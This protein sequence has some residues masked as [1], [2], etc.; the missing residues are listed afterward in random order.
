[1]TL[2]QLLTNDKNLSKEMLD[3]LRK[4]D[5]FI[6]ESFRYQNEY[7]IKNTCKH[8]RREI[9]TQNITAQSSNKKTFGYDFLEKQLI[10]LSP[11]D[12]ISMRFIESLSWGGRA[13][14]SGGGD[15]LGVFLGQKEHRNYKTPPNWEG[16]IESLKLFNKE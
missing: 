7:V 11:E 15:L 8:F 1:M 9:S 10:K 4:A 6:S 3:E 2:Q 5:A 16:S 12:A 14:F 13:Y